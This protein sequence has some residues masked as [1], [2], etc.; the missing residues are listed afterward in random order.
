MV[1]I[2]TA[3]DFP[4]IRAAIDVTIDIANLPDAVIALDINLGRATEWVVARNPVAASYAGAVDATS[5]AIRRACVLATAA[6]LAPTVPWL[7]SETFMNRTSY[8]RQ[9]TDLGTLV[10][11][12]WTQANDQIQLSLPVEEQATVGGGKPFFTVASGRRG[13]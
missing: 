2:L 10:A 1:V 9:E 4:E 6:I 11:D 8:K 7:T 12:L 13:W 3:A 5:R